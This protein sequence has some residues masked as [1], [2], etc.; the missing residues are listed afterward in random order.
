MDRK[1]LTTMEVNTAISGLM[2]GSEQKTRDM[3][4]ALPLRVR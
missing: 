3:A 2:E 4:R 1:S